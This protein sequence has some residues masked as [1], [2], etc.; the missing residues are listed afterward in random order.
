MKK[1]ILEIDDKYDDVLSITYMG[2]KSANNP[3]G[4]ELDVSSKCVDL[5]NGNHIVIDADSNMKQDFIEEH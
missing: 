1:I 2:L 4:C 3:W 5:R